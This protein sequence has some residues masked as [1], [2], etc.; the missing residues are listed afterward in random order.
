MTGYVEQTLFPGK[1]APLCIVRNGSEQPL[2]EYVGDHRAGL[3][4]KLAEHGAILFRG[5]KV[6]GAGAF[7]EFV[8]ATGDRSL[9]Y[10]FGST[11]RT[12]VSDKIYTST[13]YPANR[14]IP[15]HN[16]NAYLASWPDRLAFCCVTPSERG[17][18]T[19]IADMRDVTRSI[20]A[21]LMDR[22][23]QA[24]VEYVRHFHPGIDLSWNQVFQTS[25]PDAVAKT[26]AANGIRFD[27]IGEDG[28]LLR[29]SQICQGVA[30]HPVTGERVFFNQAHLFHA[31]SMGPEIAK[32]LRNVFGADRLPR[33][34][35]YG[36]GSEI[37]DEVIAGIHTAFRS[38]AVA[39]PWQAGDVLWLD[40]MQV[41]HGRRPYRGER[42]ILAALMESSH[43]A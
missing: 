24:R 32:E 1:R 38:H 22:F 9:D 16:E 12:L 37:P 14:E 11:P 23:G 29:T 41:A 13:E 7:S 25:D 17:G 3:E 39:F 35:R 30:C 5:F 40:N 19:P 2:S 21:E 43:A 10:R 28:S 42:R 8:G 26:C 27:W 34:A 36:D 6:D 33:H 31:T 15:L 4:S 18:E 20:S